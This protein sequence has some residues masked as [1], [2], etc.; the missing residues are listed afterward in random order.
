ML[1]I[2][3]PG[4]TTPVYVASDGAAWAVLQRRSALASRPLVCLTLTDLKA[5]AD[6]VEQAGHDHVLRFART[7]EGIRWFASCNG[8]KVVLS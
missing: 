8:A 5:L 4:I 3:L 7:V 2:R 6:G 1:T